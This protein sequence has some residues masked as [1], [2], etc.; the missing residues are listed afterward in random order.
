MDEKRLDT[1]LAA[2]DRVIA[3]MPQLL[4]TGDQTYISNYGLIRM[5]D[6]KHAID[7]EREPELPHL[8][9]TRHAS[10]SEPEKTGAN[11]P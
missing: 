5:R 4:G 10:R 7:R 2:V 3:E 9:F 6:A 1:L 8:R 11:Q